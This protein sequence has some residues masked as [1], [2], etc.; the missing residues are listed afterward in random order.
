MA[1][2]KDQCTFDANKKVAVILP[3]WPER[4]K[5]ELCTAHLKA[6]LNTLGI[7]ALPEPGEPTKA[8]KREPTLDFGP[9]EIQ[10]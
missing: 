2:K 1:D 10:E 8:I 4:G 6:V 7:T 3:C 9:E 5:L